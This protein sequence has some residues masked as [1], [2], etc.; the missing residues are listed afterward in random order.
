MLYLNIKN[1]PLHFNPTFSCSDLKSPCLLDLSS[2]PTSGS[3]Q[4]NLENEFGNI[5][6]FCCLKSFKF[7]VNH[8]LSIS[9]TTQTTKL[10]TQKEYV[11]CL[12][13][14]KPI[15][16]ALVILT[17]MILRRVLNRVSCFLSYFC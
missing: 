15:S 9:W 4:I 1:R 11:K 14:R 3:L 12:R 5:R 13:S 7:Q 2:A 17:I 6:A 8:S 10:H 16:N